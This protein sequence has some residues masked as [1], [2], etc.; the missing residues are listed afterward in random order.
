MKDEINKNFSVITELD[1]IKNKELCKPELKMQTQ[2]FIIY[3]SEL[4][5]SC[6]DKV[7]DVLESNYSKIT[8]KLRQQLKEPLTIEIHADLSQMHTALGLT[9]APDWIRGGLG[10]GKIV[11]ASPLNPP[12]GSDFNN[13]LNTAVH[14]FVHIVIRKINQNIPKWLDEGIASYEA[15]DNS[16]RW[17][18]NTVRSGLENSTIPTFSD[19]DTGAD[20]QAFFK[21]EG[22][23]YSYTIVEAIVNMFGYDKLLGLIKSPGNFEEVFGMTELELRDRWIE[24]IRNNYLNC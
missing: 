19:L 22:Y 10:K 20:F 8:D 7:S 17:I 3:Y 18:K 16:E 1:Q 13:V 9:N 4:D 11:I 2:H 6:I 12:P 14:E 21:K 23:Q 24:Y 15:K 5:K